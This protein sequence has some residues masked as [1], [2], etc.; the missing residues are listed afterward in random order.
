VV[1]S[2][3][4]THETLDP[5]RFIGN[6]SSGKM[7]FAV[8]EA[9]RDRG[10]AVTLVSGPVALATPYG[11]RRIDVTSTLELAEALREATAGCDALVMAAAPADFR[12]AAPSGEKIKHTAEGLVVGLVENPDV[13]AGLSGTFVKVG[14]AAETNDLAVN[15]RAKLAPKGL[16]FIVANDVSARDA[17]FAVDTNRVTI[18][19]ASGAAEELPLMSKLEVA[20]RILDRVVALLQKRA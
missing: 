12:P 17:G 20:D 18:I 15:A 3:G 10:A 13:V 9:A 7:G 19:D 2:A 16:D 11:V 4:G 5:V 8:A 1:V 14:F 6:R